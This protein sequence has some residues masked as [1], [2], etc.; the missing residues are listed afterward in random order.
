MPFI[1]IHADTFSQVS[2]EARVSDTEL[3]RKLNVC[4]RVHSSAGRMHGGLGL[5]WSKSNV[6]QM[7]LPARMVKSIWWGPPLKG[8]FIFLNSRNAD[9]RVNRMARPGFL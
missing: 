1:R 8:D 3:H 9:A 2:V 7:L 5:F 6:E 4:A